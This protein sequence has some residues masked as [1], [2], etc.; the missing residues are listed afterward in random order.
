MKGKK[1]SPELMEGALKIIDQVNTRS[2]RRIKNN[3][4]QKKQVRR[5][6][7]RKLINIQEI[8]P[9]GEHVTYLK[10]LANS[11]V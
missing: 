9:E 11:L 5:G 8:I 2:E 6:K 10:M 3:K 4:K 7:R 1:F